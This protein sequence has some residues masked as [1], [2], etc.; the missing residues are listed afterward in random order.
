MLEEEQYFHL[1]R[2]LNKKQ[3]HFHNHVIHWIKTKDVPLYAFLS[4]GAGVGKHVVIRALYQTLYRLLNLK[5]GE[6]QMK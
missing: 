6:T 2:S 5:E 1:L 4:G 3:K